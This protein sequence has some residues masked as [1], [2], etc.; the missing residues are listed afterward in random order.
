MGAHRIMNARLTCAAAALALLAAAGCGG[1]TPGLVHVNGK[2]TYKGQPVPSTYVTFSPADGSRPSRGLTDASGNFSLR[3]THREQGA[4]RG[5]HAV[6]LTYNPSGDEEIGKTAPRADKE[7]Q[8]VIAEFSDPG[9]P[10]LHY[11]VT[12]DGQFIEVKLD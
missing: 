10:K 11:D 7:L 12:T 8:K 3:F 6:F 2:L 1:G 5:Q 9:K 4:V